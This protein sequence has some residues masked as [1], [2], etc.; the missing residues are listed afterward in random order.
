MKILHT[1]DWHLAD[2]LKQIDRTADLQRAVERIADYCDQEQV[3]VLLVAG[4][5]LSELA[6][7]E[8]LQ[9]SVAHLSHTFRPFLL[10]G[11]TIVVLAGNH[12]SDIYCETLRRAFQLAAPS[13]AR[14]GDVVP[15]GRLYLIVR[16]V[17]FQL[18]DPHGM[19]VQFVCMPYPTTS[20]YPLRASSNAFSDFRH[21]RE[22]LRTEFVSRL[23]TIRDKL[24][25]RYPR[26]LAAHV[27]VIPG[28]STDLFRTNADA[29]VLVDDP[30]MF[31]DWT[32]VALGHLHAPQQ[33]NDWNHVRYSGSIER[34]SITEKN[35]HKGVV[36]VE[37]TSDPGR[38]IRHFLNLPATPFYDVRITNPQQELP[39]LK[40]RYPDASEALV[41]CHV[42]YRSGKDNLYDILA[43]LS[44]IFPRCYERT[45][46]AQASRGTSPDSRPHTVTGKPS[47]EGIPSNKT[48]SLDTP[49]LDTLFQARGSL[50]QTVL[51]YLNSRLADD[52][53][54]ADLLSLAQELLEED[55]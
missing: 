40:K 30:G 42:R 3:D 1:A 13:V 29:D 23:N 53:D 37:L 25:G 5:L 44:R 24:D 2:R 14:A 52:P 46:S 31:A 36:L 21:R 26:V 49:E 55:D 54:R 15:G 9:S 48:K 43:Q 39:R 45:W 10:R 32:Y 6:K 41:R 27:N 18:V 17:Q 51:E 11:G 33:V 47:C 16:P 19:P 28:R 7:P 4:D 8:S 34:L 12:D 20:R 50:R 35:Q 22:L 38:A